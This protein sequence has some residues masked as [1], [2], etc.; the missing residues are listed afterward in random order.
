MS[1][2]MPNRVSKSSFDQPLHPT[3]PTSA[4]RLVQIVSLDRRSLMAL[5]GAACALAHLGFVLPELDPA[6]ARPDK[7]DCDL[8]TPP[9]QLPDPAPYPPYRILDDGRCRAARGEL[10]FRGCHPLDD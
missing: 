10:P 1:C 6:P 2:P 5:S 9:P 4:Y 8:N 7:S 3:V